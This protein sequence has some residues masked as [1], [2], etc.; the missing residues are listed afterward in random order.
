MFFTKM[1]YISDLFMVKKSKLKVAF[2]SIF[3]K[4]LQLKNGATFMAL[5]SK[6]V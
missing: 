3:P 6:K 2:K 4:S 1:V 5:K